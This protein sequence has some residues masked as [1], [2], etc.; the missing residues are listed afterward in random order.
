VTVQA[1]PVLG[2][3]HH[4]YRR[5]ACSMD[6][7]SGHDMNGRQLVFND[8]GIWNPAAYECR[9]REI[10]E[11]VTLTSLELRSSWESAAAGVLKRLASL[12]QVDD[13]DQAIQTE[14]R[15]YSQG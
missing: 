11:G 9:E 7:K 14:L 15:L 6:G 2:G 5:A 12:F 10:I 3:L 4:D 13:A 1:V 8:P